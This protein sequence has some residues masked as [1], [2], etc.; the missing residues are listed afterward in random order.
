MLYNGMVTHR[1]LQPVGHHFDY[2]VFYLLL[3]LDELSQ[4]ARRIP[5][6]SVNKRNLVSFFTKDFGDGAPNDLKA[7]IL[8]KVMQSGLSTPVKSV[9]L[10]CIPRIFGFA[11]NPLSTF[12]C[13]DSEDNLVALV[14]DVSNTFG[15]KHSYVLPAGLANSKGVMT[16]ACS[17]EFYV[18]PFMPM[19]C[20][21]QFSVLPPR[22]TVALSIRQ[23]HDGKPIMNASFVGQRSP[24]NSHNLGWAIA[25]FPFNSLKVI[26]GI[27]WEAL[28]LWLKGLKLVDRPEKKARKPVLAK[29]SLIG[30]RQEK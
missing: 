8:E 9:R 23:F 4:L 1:R 22:E 28:K 3:D 27:H 24:L 26:A 7:S 6:L 29:P 2:R 14:Y 20:R 18:S 12:Y 5:F 16:Q 11:F 19:N 10:L 25:R 15:E 13:Y 21:Y 17:K 30:K